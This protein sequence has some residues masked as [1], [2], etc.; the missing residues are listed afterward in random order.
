MTVQEIMDKTTMNDRIIQRT[1]MTLRRLNFI[2]YIIML[3]RSFWNSLSLQDLDESVR[4]NLDTALAGR[5][6]LLLALLLLL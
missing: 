4:R 2:F 5:H 1:L 3:N 6:H